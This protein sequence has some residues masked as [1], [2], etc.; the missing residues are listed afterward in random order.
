MMHSNEFTV[1]QTSQKDDNKKDYYKWSV[2]IEP[3]ESELSEID[4]VEYL[5]HPTFP[6]RL[7]TS[8]DAT[9]NFKIDS[10]GWGE[11]RIDI[12]ISKK[13]G[14]IIQLAHW[15]SLSDD[16]NEVVSRGVEEAVTEPKK[17]YIS[18]S[19]I[20]TRTAQ[21]VESMLTDL[22]MDVSTGSDI[23]PGMVIKDYIEQSIDNADAIIT[24]NPGKENDWQKLEI[25]IANDFSKKIIPLDASDDSEENISLFSSQINL[26][27]EY[28][29]N[30]KALGDQIKNIK[31]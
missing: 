26:E 24:I 13:S 16:Q 5:L 29:E 2:W 28:G 4:Y 31:F 11:F 3:N 9:S 27:D 1:G 20:D 23:E 8:N 30:V 6:N 7:R 12:S 25:D 15:L 19:K 17:V 14:D 18:Y 22:G 21:L 10:T